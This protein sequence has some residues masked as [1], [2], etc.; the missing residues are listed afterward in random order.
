MP[1]GIILPSLSAGMEDAVIARWLKAEG[2]AVAAGEALAEIETDKA[3]MELEADAAGTVGKILVSNGER[4]DVNSVIGVLLEE[5]EGAEALTDYAQAVA[6]P[7]DAPAL[8]DA[9]AAPVAKAVVATPTATDKVIAS[10]LA[11]RIALQNGID[12]TGMSGSG[13]R[14]RIV[15]IDVERAAEQAVAA[16]AP[17][18]DV[19]ETTAKLT[20]FGEYEAVPHSTMRRTIARRLVESKT[21]IPHFY[22]EADCGLEA[23]LALRAQ[24]NEGRDKPERISVNDFLI[25]AVAHALARVPEANAVWTD[26]AILHLGTI[27]ISVAV[28]TDGGLITPVLRNADRKSLGTLSAEMKVLAVKARE[29][30]LKPVEYQGGGFSLSNL[31]MYGVKRFS[32][33]INPPQSCILAVGAA[34]RRPVERDGQIDFAPVMS[35]TLSVD[36]RSVDGAVGAQWLAAFKN[37]VET[38]MA[39]LL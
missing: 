28:A 34:E 1:K 11:R 35:V 16:P 25:K 19:A 38:P 20:G 2:E 27:D 4:A 15:R 33:I 26:D 31:G 5:G 24:V 8:K 29:G 12:L 9:T 10:P 32:A 3:T 37:A 36:H 22:L 7:A 21:T 30:R 6:K 23:L 14:G 18:A 39:L 13:P 17:Q